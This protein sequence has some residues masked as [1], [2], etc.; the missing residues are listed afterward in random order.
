MSNNKILVATQNPH[1]IQ[2]IS[3][4]FSDCDATIET[5]D[6]LPLNIEIDENGNSF[7]ENAVIKAVEYAKHYD[8]LVVATDGG[9]II[10]GLEDWDPLHTRRFAGPDATD[11]DRISELLRRMKGKTGDERQMKWCE[12]IAIA[13]AGK[14]LFSIQAPGAEGVMSDIFDEKNYRAGIWV[15]SIWEFPQFDNKNFFELSDKEVEAAE[16]SWSRLGNAL[17]AYLKDNAYFQHIE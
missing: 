1:K 9:M 2:K 3:A 8:G 4:M 11:K 17:R 6:K 13:K 16:V 14:K 15:C 5:P 7:E 12:A 10:P